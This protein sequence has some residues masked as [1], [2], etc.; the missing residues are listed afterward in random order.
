[1]ATVTPATEETSEATPLSLPIAPLPIAQL[2]AISVYWFGIN[3]L[4]GGY[5]IF[6]QWKVRPAHEQSRHPDA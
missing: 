5:E 1:M 3:A 2:L 6:G 4:W